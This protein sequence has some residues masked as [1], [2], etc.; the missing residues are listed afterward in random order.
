MGHLYGELAITTVLITGGTG[1]IGSHIV[2]SLQHKKCQIIVL[3]NL[4]T[5]HATS[6]PKDQLLIADLSN[7]STLNHIFKKNKIDVVMH[8]AGSSSVAESV[9]NPGLYYT[10]NVTNTIHL[11][12]AMCTHHVPYLIYSSTAAVYG[13]PQD[14]PIPTH[15]PTQPINPYG[16]SKRMAE[17]IIDHY[18][19]RYGMHYVCLRYFNAAGAHPDGDLKEQHEPET[20]LIPLALQAALHQTP[21]NVYGQSYE[22][23]DGTCVRDY[24]HVCDIAQAHLL[25]MN[26]LIQHRASHIINLGNGVGYTVLEVIQSV[27]TVTQRSVPIVYAPA[28]VGDPPILIA[29]SQEAYALLKWQPEYKLMDMVQHAWYSQKIRNRSAP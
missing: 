15:H 26:Y 19:K 13:H 29:D 25:A 7:Q 18:A 14:L 22:T 8:L 28:R 6:V 11:L 1:Y 4:S 17:Q 20:H 9:Q 3:D 5:G 24:I 16:S 23:K 2:R 12:D 10:N 21:L 27:E